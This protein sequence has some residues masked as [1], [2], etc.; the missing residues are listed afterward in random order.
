MTADTFIDT[1]RTYLDARPFRVFVIELHGGS[2]YE[3]DHPHALLLHG[4]AAAFWLPGGG[5]VIFDHESVNQIFLGTANTLPP[6]PG[7]T[8]TAP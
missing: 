2:R 1:T 7:T 8:P 3:V 6:L 5:P 4:A